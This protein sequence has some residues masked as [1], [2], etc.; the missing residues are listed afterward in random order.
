MSRA[1]EVPVISFTGSTATGGKNRRGVR[2][3]AQVAIPT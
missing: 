3:D 2:S 1:P